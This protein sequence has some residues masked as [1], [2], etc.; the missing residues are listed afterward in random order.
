MIEGLYAAA[1]GMRAV[2]E[3]QAVIANNIANAMTPGFRR[4]RIIDKG[5]YQLFLD[6][7]RRPYWVD[8]VRGPGGGVQTTETFSDFS[9]GVIKTS[10]NPLDVA[11]NGPAFIAVETPAGERFTRSGNLTLDAEGRLATPDGF[12]VMGDGGAI[13]ARGADVR[14]GADGAV[15]V[16]GRVSGRIRLVEFEDPHM[17][18]REGKNLFRASDAALRRSAPATETEVVPESLELSNV[19]LP[20]ELIQMTLG[21]RLYEANQRVIAAIDET[22]SRVIDQVGMPQ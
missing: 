6:K 4:Q 8:S 14:I 7:M 19:Q 13:D 17:L 20:Y 1:T 22:A 2:G 11:L 16:D 10:G 21:I 9:T 15:Y 5:F 12:L 3:R 18:V